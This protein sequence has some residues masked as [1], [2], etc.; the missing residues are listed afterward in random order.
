M[1]PAEMTEAAVRE[2]RALEDDPAKGPH[3]RVRTEEH[4]E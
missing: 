1:A 4:P 2:F 3:G